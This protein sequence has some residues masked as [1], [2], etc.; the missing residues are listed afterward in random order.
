MPLL[1]ALALYALMAPIGPRASHNRAFPNRNEQITYESYS[2]HVSM[3]FL[4]SLMA[5]GQLGA[6]CMLLSAWAKRLT[7]A[8]S[9][10]LLWVL[11]PGT[12][13]LLVT[14]GLRCFFGYGSDET[15]DRINRKIP[16]TL[17]LKP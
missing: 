2:R 17:N 1:A 15:S 16:Q 4:F 12:H 9:P 8:P 5:S 10:I 13:N 11:S 14:L 3:F 7:A 6:A